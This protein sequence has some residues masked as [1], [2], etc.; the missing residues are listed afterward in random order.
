M[1]PTARQ[2]VP[3]MAMAFS[4]PGTVAG[5]A[6]N[7]RTI[8]A[9]AAEPLRL[10][11]LGGTY[12][13]IWPDIPVRNDDIL[14]DVHIGLACDSGARRCSALQKICTV[15]GRPLLCRGLRTLTSS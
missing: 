13:T 4:V 11:E 5:I 14:H 15:A 2:V 6:V 7:R 10:C 9:T 12:D 8:D 1:T 3:F